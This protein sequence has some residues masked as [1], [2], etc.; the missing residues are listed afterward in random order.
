MRP[1]FHMAVFAWSISME[2]LLS[3]KDNSQLIYF[4][5]QEP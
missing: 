2:D 3:G 5:K 4:L 1:P